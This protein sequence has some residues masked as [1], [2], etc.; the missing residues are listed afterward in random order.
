MRKFS[1]T[2]QPVADAET[3]HSDTDFSFRN[4]VSTYPTCFQAFSNHRISLSGIEKGIFICRKKAFPMPENAE[5]SS[6]K[7]HSE[8]K[9]IAS[10]HRK[11]QKNNS[12][13]Q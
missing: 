13:T 3:A 11:L 10:H 8:F 2:D 4:T 5:L 9:N 12:F 6:E 7:K 1:D